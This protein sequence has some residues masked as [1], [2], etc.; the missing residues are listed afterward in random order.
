MPATDSNR[1]VKR[2]KRMAKSDNNKEYLDQVYYAIGNVYMAQRDTAKAIEAYEEGNK[3]S[4]RNGIEKG[5]LLLTL[6]N[7]Y[8]QLSKYGD[9]QRCYGEAIGLLDKD[10]KDYAQLSER[11]KI[12]DELAPHTNAVEL[13]DSLQR[14]AKMSEEDRNK[15]IDKLIADLLEKEKEERYAQEEA[16]AEKVLQKQSAMNN[17]MGTSKTTT[18]PTVP[19]SGKSDQWYF[20]NPQAVSQGKLA[21]QR[22]WGKRENQDNWQRINQTVVNLFPNNEENQDSTD[23]ADIPTATDEGGSVPGDSL[24]SAAADSTALD[25]HNREYYLAQIPFTEEQLAESH[26]LIKDGLFHAGI[27]FKDKMD[28]LRLCEKSLQRLLHDYPDYDHNDEA[29]YHLFL[30][31]SRQQD[32]AAADSCLE[33]L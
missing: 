32:T 27:I 26:N 22:Q 19:G 16:E 8:W 6:G 13:Q 1:K 9:A 12:L 23:V 4:T 2:L 10:R 20:Y 30:L 25:P 14:L 24:A 33:R 7:L 21:F 11:S 29:L 31:Y 28:D 5:V 3:K 18:P 15:V 17:S